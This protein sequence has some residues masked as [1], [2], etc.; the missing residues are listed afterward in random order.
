MSTERPV[1]PDWVTIPN[2]LTL[3]RL[4][5]LLPVCWMLVDKGPDALSVILLLV[6]ASTDWLDGM[7]ARR[8]HQTSRT[9]EIL[10]P[11]ADRIG[12]IGI[13]VSLAL[14]G[15]LPWSVL[16]VIAAGDVVATALA[17]REAMRGGI[18]VSR[19]GKVRTAVLMSAVL[20]LAAAGAWA[21]G[22]VPAVLVLM[23][24]GVALHL[25]ASIGYVVSARSVPADAR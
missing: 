23:W 15:L 2:A 25:L 20:L 22:V 6:W 12:L 9:G 1:R 7:L 13:V 16:L 3:L 24:I 18:G 8:L 5:L 14:T 11:V 4:V 21:P 10:D 17:G 19:I